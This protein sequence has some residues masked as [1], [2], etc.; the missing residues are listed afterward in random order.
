[1]T[2]VVFN[3]F[4]ITNK[5]EAFL[6]N[7]HEINLP[8]PALE[9]PTLSICDEKKERTTTTTRKGAG[10]QALPVIRGLLLSADKWF[11]IES[12]D[13]YHFP[14]TFKLPPPKD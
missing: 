4:H 7:N 10:S 5:G 8:T 12:C 9:S 13:D 6:E 3:V 2:G 14:G 1:M 11:P